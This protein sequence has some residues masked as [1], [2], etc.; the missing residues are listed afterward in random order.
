VCRIK[1]LPDGAAEDTYIL[2]EEVEFDI[3]RQMPK[4]FA[5]SYPKQDGP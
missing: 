3:I 4:S 5:A 2:A 1:E